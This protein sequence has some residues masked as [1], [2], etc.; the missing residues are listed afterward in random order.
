[1]ARIYEI[2]IKYNVA[3]MARFYHECF[4]TKFSQNKTWLKSWP[5]YQNIPL[6]GLVTKFFMANLQNIFFVKILS[7]TFVANK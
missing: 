2:S 1:M 7:Q 3:K 5:V 6:S 4:V